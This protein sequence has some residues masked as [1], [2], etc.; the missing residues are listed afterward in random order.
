VLGFAN[1]GNFNYGVYGTAYGGITDY[2]GYFNGPIYATN[3]TTTSDRKLKQD[4]QPLTSGL[5]Q[6]LKL[7][8]ATYQYKTKEYKHMNL[9]EG[10]QV[11]LVADEVKQV[12]PQLV[13]SVVQPAQYNEKDK[14][15]EISPEV[16]FEGVNYQGLIPVLIA[17]IQE[18]QQQIMDKDEKI[19]NLEARLQK[20]EALLN[21]SNSLPLN[22]ATLLQNVP[23]PVNGTTTIRYQVP[24]TAKTASILLTDVKGQQLKAIV[25]SN[26]GSAQVS[27]DT[28][29]LASGTYNYTLYVD[30]QPADTKRLVVTR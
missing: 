6:L 17:S 2:A 14:T 8:P 3:I 1:G 5:E 12:F 11:G 28:Q 27:L 9:P 20:I 29:G 23:N 25:L 10:K 30:G 4:I 19:A 15:K 22:S 7:R 13:R 16:K 18:Q 21:G 26:R 24:T